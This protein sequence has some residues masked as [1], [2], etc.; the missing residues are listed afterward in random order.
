V[1]RGVEPKRAELVQL[2]DS[3][4]H[5]H[6]QGKFGKNSESGKDIGAGVGVASPPLANAW[7][8]THWGECLRGHFTPGSEVS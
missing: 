2:F 6:V 3:V 7:T 1:F 4:A 8:K 5:N